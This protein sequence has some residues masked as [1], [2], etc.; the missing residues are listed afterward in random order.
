MFA[1]LARN[2][3][4]P[5][6]RLALA[7]HFRDVKLLTIFVRGTARAAVL[8][9]QHGQSVNNRTAA[10]VGTAVNVDTMQ[11]YIGTLR[12]CMMRDSW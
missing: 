3:S 2:D 5:E 10:R 7:R 12:V 9:R 11:K 8:E 4:S 6:V 1:C